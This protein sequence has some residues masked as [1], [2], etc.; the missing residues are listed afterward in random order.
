M[1]AIMREPLAMR[2][3]SSRPHSTLAETERWVES[4]IPVDPAM[5][6]DFIVTLNGALIG[7][8]GTWKL[9]EIGFLIA[10]AYWGHGYA[11]EA[12]EVFIERRRELG[13]GELIADVDPRNLASLRLLRRHGFVE[14]GRVAGTWQVGEE[15]C[16]SVYLRIELRR[17]A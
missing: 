3:W 15:M 11:S 17:P 1:H 4:M 6:D 12:L 10:P 16:D 8:L 9:P 13:S 2:Y 14:T 7:K 5:S